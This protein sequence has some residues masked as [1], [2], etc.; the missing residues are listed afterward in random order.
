MVMKQVL[1]I[2]SRHSQNKNT[3][4]LLKLD[5][6]INDKNKLSVKYSYLHATADQIINSTGTPNSGSYTY[7]GANG[8]P[9]TRGNGGLPNG[10]FGLKSMGFENSNYGFLNKVSTGTAEL[11]STISPKLSNQL[12]L[13]FKKYDNPRTSK[14]S[15][16]PTIDI[17]NGAGDNYNY[18]R[19]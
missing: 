15:I 16:F 14:G 18:S 4:V 3:K 5:W 7:T 1:M 11:N 17:F 12:L 13:T 6:N 19:F 2:T 9:Q 8:L 10:R